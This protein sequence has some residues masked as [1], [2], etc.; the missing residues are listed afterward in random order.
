ML[1][2]LQFEFEIALRT[3]QLFTVSIVSTNLSK[4]FLSVYR[5]CP[6]YQKHSGPSALVPDDDSQNIS[7][8]TMYNLQGD[9]GQHLGDYRLGS[10]KR[11]AYDTDI[12]VPFLV[13][14]K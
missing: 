11:Q 2:C 3:T 5:S 12:R 6:C 14:S 8:A 9:N 1:T 4:S 7:F 10:G 13:S